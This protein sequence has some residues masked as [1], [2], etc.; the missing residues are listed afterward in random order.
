MKPDN[1]SLVALVA[2]AAGGYLGGEGRGEAV[3]GAMLA[4]D[5]AAFLPPAVRGLAYRDQPVEIGEGQ[6]CS[7]P[8]M[9]AFMLELLELGPGLRLLEI[10]SGCGYAAAIAARLCGSDGSILAVEILPALAALCRANCASLSDRIEVVVGDGS[11]GMADRAPFDRILV[12]AGVRRGRFNE[13]RLVA[14]LVDGGVLVYP[15]ERG[16]LFR[17]RRRGSTLLRE[18]YGPVAFVPLVGKNA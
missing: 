13:A 15:E 1:A 5:R 17:V 8:S 11:G 16:S 4:T 7:Q 14:C 10:G 3:L 2:K 18:S 6:T 9:V 12:S